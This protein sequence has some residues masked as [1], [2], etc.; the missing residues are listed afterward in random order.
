MSTKLQ[1]ILNNKAKTNNR[2]DYSKYQVD[3]VTETIADALFFLFI[4]AKSY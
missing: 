2:I 1:D 4:L 3:E